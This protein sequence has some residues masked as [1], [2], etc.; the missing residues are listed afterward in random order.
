MA[1]LKEIAKSE[2][3]VF[4]YMCRIFGLHAGASACAGDE[5]GFSKTTTETTVHITT[6]QRFR[7]RRGVTVCEQVD[8]VS[9]T[10]PREAVPRRLLLPP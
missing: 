4:P 7:P 8:S 1:L 5:G 3:R 2:G 6:L 10:L 9:S